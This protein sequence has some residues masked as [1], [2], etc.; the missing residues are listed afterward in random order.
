MRTVGQL[1]SEVIGKEAKFNFTVAFFFDCFSA[2]LECCK[3]QENGTTIITATIVHAHNVVIALLCD[4]Y[5]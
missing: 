4:H 5:G 1:P 3:K 2:H